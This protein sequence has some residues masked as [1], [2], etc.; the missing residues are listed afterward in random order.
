MSDGLIYSKE[1]Q[2]KV[3]AIR[4]QL[5]AIENKRDLLHER[6]QE[7]QAGQS[8]I[9]PGDIIT[10]ESGKNQRRGRVKSVRSTWN[11][12][13]YR[14]HVLTKT[15]KEVGYANVDSSRCPILELRPRAKKATAP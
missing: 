2:R 15:G 10:W 4:K 5:Q 9:Q 13:E 8:P 7:L 12:F 3:R 6:I 1:V 14:C 11:N